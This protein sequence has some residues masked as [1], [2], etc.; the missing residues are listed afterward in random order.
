VNAWVS[1]ININ[2]GIKEPTYGYLQN[3]NTNQLMVFGGYVKARESLFT[4]VMNWV[5]TILNH[6]DTWMVLPRCEG[7]CMVHRP[8]VY[9]KQKYRQYRYPYGVWKKI[10]IQHWSIPTQS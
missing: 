3:C 2:S 9:R 8:K 6:I 5:T 1:I 10:K 4:R 7:V